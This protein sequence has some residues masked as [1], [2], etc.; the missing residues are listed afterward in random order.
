MNECFCNSFTLKTSQAAFSCY[1]GLNVSVF[2]ATRETLKASRSEPKNTFCVANDLGVRWETEGDDCVRS[3]LGVGRMRRSDICKEKSRRRAG[4]RGP[5]VWV[6]CLRGCPSF[7][8]KA[9]DLLKGLYIP[10]DQEEPRGSPGGSW[11]IC[12]GRKD[13][14]VLINLPLFQRK[15]NR[16]DG[17]DRK[18][19]D[20]WVPSGCC[21]F[22]GVGPISPHFQYKVLWCISP[23][24]QDCTAYL[25]Q[26]YWL[27]IF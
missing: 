12:A 8:A 22:P 14:D 27:D 21:F 25:S 7:K 11:N 6:G 5:T 24:K 20:K 9:K 16:L 15:V 3:G 10:P 19:L 2:S 1:P 26:M 13:L 17:S 18:R 23:C 4:R